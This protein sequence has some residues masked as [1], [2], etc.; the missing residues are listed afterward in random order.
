MLSSPHP[1]P[2]TTFQDLCVILLRRFCK[3]GCIRI[4]ML[5]HP[6]ATP[7][8]GLV[9]SCFCQDSGTVIYKM[10]R[11]MLSQEEFWPLLCDV[12][13]Q[14]GLFS[15]S[16]GLSS[17]HLITWAAEGTAR[18]NLNPL[19]RSHYGDMAVIMSGAPLGGLSSS[20]TDPQSCV[21]I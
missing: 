10:L 18:E 14:K 6:W 16:P 12:F 20:N 21:H 4:W 3:P 7:L 11:L 19:P 17:W 5:W 2:S 13:I 15:A 8:C 9:F 1:P